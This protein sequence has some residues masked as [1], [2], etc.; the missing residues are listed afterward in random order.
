MSYLR[1]MAR[2][3]DAGL[4]VSTVLLCICLSAAARDASNY[5][6]VLGPAPGTPH[7]EKS[8]RSVTPTAQR[9]SP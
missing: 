4:I 7:H 3:R 1:K 2:H 9:T 5:E 8:Y 6:T